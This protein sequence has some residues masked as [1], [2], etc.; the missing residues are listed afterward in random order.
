MGPKGPSPPAML[1]SIGTR[2]I[3][4]TPPAT[5]TSAYPATT[6][7][8]AN[9]TACWLEPHCRSTVTPTTSSGHPAA[10]TALRP[11]FTDCSPTCDTQ[12]HT[13]SSMSEGSTPVR[14]ASSV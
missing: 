8:A 3:D 4:S 5:T 14:W 12:P 13:T 10:M 9:C 11:T 2:D 7:A 6:D 1:D